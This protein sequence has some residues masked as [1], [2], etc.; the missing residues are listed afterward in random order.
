[1]YSL[2]ALSKDNALKVN[3]NIVEKVLILISVLMFLTSNKVPFNQTLWKY[4][5]T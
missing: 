4:C 3:L 2:F 1:M 5:V